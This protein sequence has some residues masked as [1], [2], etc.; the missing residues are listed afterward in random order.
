MSKDDELEP[1]WETYESCCWKV[2]AINCFVLPTFSSSQINTD[3]ATILKKF[4]IA[5]GKHVFSKLNGCFMKPNTH[6]PILLLSNMFFFLHKISCVA[7]EMN[8][9]LAFVK[10]AYFEFER[11]IEDDKEVRTLSLFDV[12]CGIP[13][14]KKNIMEL[15]E[16]MKAVRP[17]LQIIWLERVVETPYDDECLVG[18]MSW[19][20]K[21]CHQTLLQADVEPKKA[22]FMTVPT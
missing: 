13:P 20:T 3:K 1:E 8:S 7:F 22:R 11:N 9:F 4:S 17:H 2:F 19:Q 18:P 21:I 14:R 5:C 10:Q 15:S 6:L 16:L 12:H